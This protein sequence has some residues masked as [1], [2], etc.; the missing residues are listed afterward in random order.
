MTT[1]T[2]AGEPFPLGPGLLH[3]G[4]TGS[5]IDVSCLVNN[6]VITASK[7]QGDSVTKLCGTVRPG[8]VSYEYS[9]SGNLD[10]DIADSDGF[11]ALSQA[12]PGK[13]Y[14]Y[15]FEPNSEAGTSAAGKLVIDPLDFGGDETGE[16]MNSDFEF[17]LVGAPT[18]TY[19]GVAAVAASED[20]E[21][22]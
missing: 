11:F 20:R 7:D 5:L 15:T 12:N 9:L 14:D 10:T 16:T 21:A 6:A 2:V 17:T 4:A 3:I 18:Y 1:P 8:A 22:S 13:E 19:G